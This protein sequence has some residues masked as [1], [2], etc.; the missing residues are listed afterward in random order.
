M[1]AFTLTWLPS[2]SPVAIFCILLII[3]P[4][5][6]LLRLSSRGSESQISP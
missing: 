4:I 3:L 2:I 1:A 5:A 6:I